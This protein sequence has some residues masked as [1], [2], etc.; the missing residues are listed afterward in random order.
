MP[1]LHVSALSLS[2]ALRNASCRVT[3][4]HTHTQ[5]DRNTNGLPYAS[6]GLRP[7]RHNNCT[8]EYLLL[9]YQDSLNIYNH[10]H[11]IHTLAYIT[12]PYTNSVH[13]HCWKLTL[14][15]NNGYYRSVFKQY[16]QPFSHNTLLVLVMS[17]LLYVVHWFVYYAI[18]LCFTGTLRIYW[19]LQTMLSGCCCLWQAGW[20]NHSWEGI[21]PL[22]LD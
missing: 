3:H 17:G 14:S 18:D 22:L 6:G 8:C 7:P 21:E 1:A 2:R 12:F 13:N 9:Q 16:C 20:L 11:S 5:T 10:K 19:I 4:T 15:P